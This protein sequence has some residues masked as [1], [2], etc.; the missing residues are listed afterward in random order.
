MASTRRV[1]IWTRRVQSRT[2]DQVFD[3]LKHH[4]EIYIVLNIICSS[5]G[6]AYIWGSRYISFD[7][8]LS[9]STSLERKGQNHP[10]I[11]WCYHGLPDSGNIRIFKVSNPSIICHQFKS[12]KLT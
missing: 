11:I 12:A 9:S 1:H 6:C 8:A 10:N 5:V 4:M 2:R 7:C 3:F